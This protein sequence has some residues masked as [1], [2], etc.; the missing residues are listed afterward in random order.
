MSELFAHWAL[1]AKFVVVAAWHG[2][3]SALAIVALGVVSIGMLAF[4]A[5]APFWRPSCA[6]RRSRIPDAQ[7]EWFCATC[8]TTNNLPMGCTKK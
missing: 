2:D 6:W 1:G 8:G 4:A 7:H 3:L 5:A